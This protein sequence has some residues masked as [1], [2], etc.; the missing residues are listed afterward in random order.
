M[1]RVDP[2]RATLNSYFEKPLN[3]KPI[4]TDTLGPLPTIDINAAQARSY[5]PYSNS[6]Y[7]PSSTVYSSHTLVPPNDH[8]RNLFES[9]SAEHGFSKEVEPH[10]YAHPFTPIKDE[11]LTKNHHETTTTPMQRDYL[12]VPPATPLAVGPR[13]SPKKKLW[14]HSFETGSRAQNPD[15]SLQCASRIVHCGY[16]WNDDQIG[17]LVRAFVWNASTG[18]VDGHDALAMLAQRVHTSFFHFSMNRELGG[19]FK[20]A[21]HATVLGTFSASWNGVSFLL[22]FFSVVKA[23]N[24]IHI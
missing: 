11:F 18:L 1:S 20:C 2:L 9:A 23:D 6:T 22:F 4:R 10:P 13:I 24:Y 16:E 7:S 17:D 19:I 8:A 12:S 3:S 15:F 21:L 14:T 5:S